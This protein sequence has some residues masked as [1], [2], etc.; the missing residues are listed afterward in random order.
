M[1]LKSIAE[2]DGNYF[3]IQLPEKPY[4]I[5]WQDAM[6][7]KR[8]FLHKEIVSMLVAEGGRG[9]THLLALLGMCVS[10]GIPFLDHFL[11]ERPGAVCVIFGENNEEDIQRLF[12]KTYTHLKNWM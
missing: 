6:Q 8:P 10:C 12:Y 11:I 1:E 9:K 2:I 7:I 4:L 3:K 5:Y